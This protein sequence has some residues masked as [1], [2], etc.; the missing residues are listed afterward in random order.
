MQNSHD[1]PRTLCRLV[2]THSPAHE[3][4]P[5]IT[6]WPQGPWEVGRSGLQECQP[7]SQ[8]HGKA[9]I[10]KA[11]RLRAGLETGDQEPCRHWHLRRRLGVRKKETRN[12]VRG[13]RKERDVAVS[14]LLANERGQQTLAT[15]TTPTLAQLLVSC[16]RQ[17]GG[18]CALSSGPCHGHSSSKTWALR[19]IHLSRVPLI[20]FS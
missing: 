15:L 5:P 7:H 18:T 6:F 3:H 16:P 12:E 11:E 20:S 10:E 17:W 14:C 19:V 4:H 2:L 13:Q 9:W 1:F 8:G